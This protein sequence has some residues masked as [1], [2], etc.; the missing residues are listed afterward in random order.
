LGTFHDIFIDRG[1]N[2]FSRQCSLAEESV[3]FAVS[4]R[5]TVEN[6]VTSDFG[7]G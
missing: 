3:A 6:V 1:L 2:G 7:Q 4:Q 5:L